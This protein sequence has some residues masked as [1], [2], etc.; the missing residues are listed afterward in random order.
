MISDYL[1]K[2]VLLGD[3]AVGKSSILCRFA[4]CW[5]L[6]T[7]AASR[8]PVTDRFVLLQDDEF[9][10]EHVQTTGV[11]FVCSIVAVLHSVHTD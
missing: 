1:F 5:A 10:D 3:A 11:D 2:L 8:P 9:T 7:F 4:V 6:C